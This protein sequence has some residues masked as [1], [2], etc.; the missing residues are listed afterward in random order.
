MLPLASSRAQ[1]KRIPATTFS[2]AQSARRSA[3]TQVRR[4]VRDNGVYL[5]NFCARDDGRA[6]CFYRVD[7]PIYF[8]FTKQLRESGLQADV[9]VGKLKKDISFAL[10]R[11]RF[12]GA[13]SP[14]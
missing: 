8:L 12:A 10:R 9:L 1:R 5:L 6:R 7:V 3:N 14:M 11:L 2:P 4:H 13:R